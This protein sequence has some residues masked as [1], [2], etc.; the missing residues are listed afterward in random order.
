MSEV[1]FINND[2]SVAVN[3]L[4]GNNIYD[5]MIGGEMIL[6]L[7]SPLNDFTMNNI[8]EIIKSMFM[9]EDDERKFWESLSDDNKSA[10]IYSTTMKYDTDD[11]LYTGYK[12]DKNQSMQFPRINNFGCIIDVPY[13]IKVGLLLQGIKNSISK[14]ND[15]NDEYTSLR[16]KGIKTYK[17]KEFIHPQ[18]QIIQQK[19]KETT[20]ECL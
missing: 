10:L 19:I 20:K 17:I 18:D 15:K 16:N 6:K 3:L 2:I 1:K 11:M 7:V 14:S 12:K 9:S 5:K 13:M 4:S 8:Y